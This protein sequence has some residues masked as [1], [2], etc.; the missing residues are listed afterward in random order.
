MKLMHTKTPDYIQKMHNAASKGGPTM[1]LYIRGMET[2]RGGKWASVKTGQIEEVTGK[3]AQEPGVAALEM[4]IMN[5][6]PEVMKVVLLKARDKDGKVIKI[7]RFPGV[8]VFEPLEEVEYEG[9]RNVST[10]TTYVLPN[11]K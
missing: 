1:S 8:C 10:H 2:V 4:V 9:C 3:V 7:V 5:E 6:N 11:E